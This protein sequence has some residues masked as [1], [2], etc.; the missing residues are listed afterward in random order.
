MFYDCIN[1]FFNVQND[2]FN[3]NFVL[4]R[5][6]LAFIF[7]FIFSLFGLKILINYLKEHKV[8]QPIRAEGPEG[9]LLS[10]QKTPTMGGLVSCV[11][12]LLSG[13]LFTNISDIYVIGALIISILFGMIGLT[14]DVMKVFYKNTNGFKG[15]IKL[16]LQMFICGSVILWLI[17]N[18][19]SVL[20]EST[21]FIPFFKVM[22]YLGILFI[23]FI[24]LVIVGSS[25]AVNLSDGLDGLVIIPV[26][27]CA[28]VL[29]IISI[30]NGYGVQENYIFVMNYDN[31]SELA[32][33]CS[34][35]IGTGLAFFIYNRHPAKIFMGDVGSLMYGAFLGYVAVILKY[36]I[37]YGIAGLIFIIEAVSVIMQVASY[38]IFKKRIFKMAPIHHHFEKCGWSERKVV[39][40]F[41][42]FSVI[43]LLVAIFGIVK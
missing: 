29:G 27:L 3:I 9:H 30:A 40:S 34:A 12:L 11:A 15:G 38:K 43:C 23:P 26:M 28:L 22:I 13:L 35:I 41:W 6:L 16:I 21:I 17:Y 4:T 25:N 37:F 36:E 10:K 7:S 39:L 18:D 8:F 5:S 2:V 24:M 31:P 33:L 1:S 32:I 20:N 19:S 14:D 42:A